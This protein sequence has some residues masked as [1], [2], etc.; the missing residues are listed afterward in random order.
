MRALDTYAELRRFGRPIV[1]TDDVAVRTR[2]S[3]SAAAR[4][5]ERLSTR[6]LVKPLRRGL[7]AVDPN[8]DPLLVPEY[9]TA[10]LPAYISF[11]SALY[12]HRMISQ[13]PHVIY[14]ASLARTRRVRTAIGTYSIHQIAPQFFGGFETSRS[15]LRLATPEKALLDLLYLTA[16]KSRLFAR[17]PEIE[18]P[19]RFSLRECRRWIARIPASYRRTMVRRRLEALLASADR[20]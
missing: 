8:V 17:L 1:T 2:A 12:L 14:V 18:L 5:L 19:A 6:G 4:I 13:L 3:T 11:Q 7:W 10:P 20:P 15:Q 16:A 9:L